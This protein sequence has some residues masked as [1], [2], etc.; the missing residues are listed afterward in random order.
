MKN[1]IENLLVLDFETTGLSPEKDYPTEIGFKKHFKHGKNEVYNEMIRLPEGVEVPE[2][3]TN[4]TGLTT[5]QVNEKGIDKESIKLKLESAID[6]NTLV[7]AHNANFDLGFLYHHFGVK[8]K[9]FMCTRTIEFLTHPH[10]SSSLEPTYI[11]YIGEIEQEHRA[12]ADVEM[13]MEVLVKQKEIH[14]DHI[15]YFLNKMVV[16]PERKLVYQPDNAIVLDFEHL[17]QLKK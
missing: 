12:L 3:I 8:P 15:Y 13:T 4:L 16:T 5:Q 11:R 2:F 1:N 17:F 6:E 9:Y 10:E 7:V 14:G